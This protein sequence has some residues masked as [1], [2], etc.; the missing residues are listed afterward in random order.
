MFLGNSIKSLTKGG[1]P[2]TLSSPSAVSFLHPIG[3]GI[4]QFSEKMNDQYN[5]KRIYWRELLSWGKITILASF[6]VPI[7]YF[8]LATLMVERDVE[9][10][11]SINI[12][13]VIDIFFIKNGIYI[14]FGTTLLLDL[15]HDY[16]S[17][18]DVFN[19]PYFIL[20]FS[21]IFIATFPF[22][23]CAI[24]YVT[25]G[26]NIPL[27]ENSIFYYSFFTSTVLFVVYIKN[28]IFINK[29]KSGNNE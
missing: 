13:K 24:G 22:F 14:F 28:K 10:I 5:S 8:Y 23:I 12:L 21:V 1:F 17:T 3:N 15:L 11:P 6:C 16:K 9:K 25:P 26:A 18:P 7:I 27:K 29:S 4:Y 2:V 19:K 20:I